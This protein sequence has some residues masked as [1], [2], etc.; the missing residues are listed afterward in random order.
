MKYADAFSVGGFELVALETLMLPDRLQQPFGWKTVFLAQR[1]DIAATFAPDGIKIS[2]ARFHAPSFLR[3]GS[4]S[5][6]GKNE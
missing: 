3:S 1:A 6:A 4:E 5:Q 2:P